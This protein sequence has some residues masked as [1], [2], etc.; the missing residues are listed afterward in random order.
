MTTLAEL[1]R[2]INN[3]CQIGTISEVYTTQRPKDHDDYA[4]FAKVDVMGRTTDFFPVMAQIGEFKKHY[5]PP[6]VGEQV[7]VMC[8]FGNAN[9]GY[10][11]RGVFSN[12]K[13]PITHSVKDRTTEYI[14]YKDGTKIEISL[15]DKKIKLDTPMDIE[16]KSAKNIKITCKNSTLI[17]DTVKVDSPSIDLGL[18]GMGVVTQ[19]CVC[20]I[21]GIPHIFGSM[22]TRSKI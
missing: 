5:C 11:M 7:M 13:E 17:A 15:Y 2:K 16:V 9:V 6:Y 20:P 3:I 10:I 14:E 21:M 1:E 8:P 19:E 22:N 12:D 18:G 4:L